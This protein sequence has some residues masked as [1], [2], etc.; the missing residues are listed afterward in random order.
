MRRLQPQLGFSLPLTP[1]FRLLLGYHW[2]L[3][4]MP[5]LSPRLLFVMKSWWHNS[6]FLVRV[7]M[8]LIRS[9]VAK[10]GK[11]NLLLFYLKGPFQLLG[12]FYYFV[13]SITLRESRRPRRGS[14]GKSWSKQI[15]SLLSPNVDTSPHRC[16]ISL[17]IMCSFYYAICTRCRGRRRPEFDSIKSRVEGWKI[18]AFF[19]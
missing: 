5:I 12:S 8:F 13:M 14:D 1:S 3:L 2:W 9:I 19:V 16:N 17:S 4:N 6:Y 18:V 10:C 7:K 11:R 15:R